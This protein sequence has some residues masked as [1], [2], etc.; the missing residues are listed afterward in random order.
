MRLRPPLRHLQV[1]WWHRRWGIRKLIQSLQI[2][3]QLLRFTAWQLKGEGLPKVRGIQ[4]PLALYL[5]LATSRVVT[6]CLLRRMPSSDSSYLPWTTSTTSIARWPLSS[7]RDNSC[8]TKPSTLIRAS[9]LGFQAPH[10]SRGT[11]RLTDLIKEW[12]RGMRLSETRKEAD[13]EC[14]LPSRACALTI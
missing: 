8:Q 13:R 10:F 4:R 14:S 2:R 1:A 12:K 5:P 7:A 11:N 6:S 9:W 3:W